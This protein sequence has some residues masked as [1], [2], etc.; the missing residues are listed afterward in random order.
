MLG[1]G[2][3]KI[4]IGGWQFSFK[5]LPIDRTKKMTQEDFNL[6]TAAFSII[7]AKKGLVMQM[8][9]NINNFNSLVSK[10]EGQK[11]PASVKKQIQE[12]K[13]KVKKIQKEKEEIERSIPKYEKV[14]NEL[15]K[16]YFK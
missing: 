1:D 7:R 6:F 4:I 8:E 10:Y 3:Y 14:F 2:L 16:K 12:V 5:T 13:D 9:G 15:D 11:V